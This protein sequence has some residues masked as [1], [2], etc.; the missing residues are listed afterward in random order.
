LAQLHGVYL[1]AQNATGLVL[2]DIHAAHERVTYE[3]LK[4][5]LAEGDLPRQP[6]LLPV[7]VTLA[8]AEAERAEA[9]VETFQRCGIEVQRVGPQSLAVRSLPAALIGVDAGQLIRDMLA[10]HAV[11]ECSHQTEQRIHAILAT[12]ACH[13]SV[14]A[15]Q[16]LSLM[17]MNALLREMEETERAD[18]CGHGRPTWVQW[19]MTELD[20]LFLRGR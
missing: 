20:K 4:R 16:P 19:T 14:R 8:A 2:V 6:L 10:D 7:M 13:T 12:L 1:L 3:R 11:Y 9:L 5:L 17:E 15:R 18:Q